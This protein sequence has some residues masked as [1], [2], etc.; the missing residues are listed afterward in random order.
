MRTSIL[1]GTGLL[2]LALAFVVSTTQAQDNVKPQDTPKDVK[3]DVT[4]PKTIDVKPAG[5]P[6]GT[7]STF[8]VQVK[9]TNNGKAP[10][11]FSSADV[12]VKMKDQRGI[13]VE[14]LADAAQVPAGAT[15]ERTYKVSTNT[16]TPAKGDHDI[17]FRVYSDWHKGKVTV[18]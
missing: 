18:K 3:V 12:D 1:F 9:V 2:T 6:G 10:I 14:K 4:F 8:E 15:A 5:K 11:V 13:T 16:I 7:T 17:E